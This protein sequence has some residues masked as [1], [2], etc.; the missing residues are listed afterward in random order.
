MPES[1][2]N[3]VDKKLIDDPME[4]KEL[5]TVGKSKNNYLDGLITV[6]KKLVND[7]MGKKELITAEKSK[8]KYLDCLLEKIKKNYSKGDG[9]RDH[10][11][12]KYKLCRIE[13]ELNHDKMFNDFFFE[14][15]Q[16]FEREHENIY[17]DHLLEKMKNIYSKGDNHH[18]I[19]SKLYKNEPELEHDEIFRDFF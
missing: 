9:Y 5:I 10:L 12:I 17:S 19:R 1:L 16:K 13:P 14:T 7:S 4:K 18:N 8:N 15:Y 3:T 11:A 2:K 6:D